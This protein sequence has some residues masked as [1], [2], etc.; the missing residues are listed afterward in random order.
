MRIHDA[1]CLQELNIN[2]QITF[3]G[4]Q[5]FM[6]MEGQWT[7]SWSIDGR[8]YERFDGTEVSFEWGYDG[9][10]NPWQADFS[11]VVTTFELDDLEMCLLTSWVRTGYWLTK[12]G[13][14]RLNVQ[15]K[16]KEAQTTATELPL[17]LAIH[18]KNS[19]VVANVLIDEKHWLPICLTTEVHGGKDTWE[20][21]E[22][23]YLT[24]DRRCKFPWSIVHALPAGGKSIIIAENAKV[25]KM[26]P[27]SNK[28]IADFFSK[29]VSFLVPR[30]NHSY[31]CTSMDASRPSVKL[32]QAESGHYLVRPILDGKDIGYFVVDTGASGF[33]ITSEKAKELNMNGFGE[34]YLLSVEGPVKSRF[35]RARSFQLGPLKISNPLF[36][37]VPM[38]GI[39]RGVSP[40]AGIC[41]FDLFCHCI[42]EMSLKEETL[43]LFD[44][45]KYQPPQR[46]SIQWQTMHMLDNVPHV[47]AKVNGKDTILLLDTGAGGV[48]LIF[49]NRAVEDLNLFEG[50]NDMRSAKVRGV[51][52]SS[53][54]LE[55]VYGVLDTLEVAGQS[56]QKVNALLFPK[57]TGTLE[58]SKYTAGIL[59]GQLLASFLVIIDYRQRKLALIGVDPISSSQH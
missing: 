35:V 38:D 8:F 20:Y 37:E 16:V 9:K 57:N 56:F 27:H 43:S 4:K 23:H 48:D 6:G 59:A 29:P 58:F 41:G 40:V 47:P 18:L 28:P 54:G 3:S 55:V 52:S 50:L 5:K 14:K 15:L 32:I 36:V 17:E 7:F 44:P 46:T 22:W 51:S 2:E 49:H 39:V 19:K 45:I 11:G 31:S 53:G 33:S 21:A 10:N 34:V 30:F 13:Q 25:V 1:L 42:I 26:E 24:L 12:E